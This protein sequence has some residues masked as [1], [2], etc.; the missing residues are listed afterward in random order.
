VLALIALSCTAFDAAA[1]V[2]VDMNVSG[3]GSAG[4][5]PFSAGGG[6]YP[7]SNFG[8]SANGSLGGANID[9][10]VASSTRFAFPS[11]NNGDVLQPGTSS[12]AVALSPQWSGS[13]SATS[14]LTANVAFQYNLGP[15]SG[16]DS[17]FSQNLGTSASGSI[18]NAGGALSSNS[19]SNSASGTVWNYHLGLD[20]GV[21]SAS[22]GITVG[23]T[24][25]SGANYSPSAQYGVT[26]WVSTD[27]GGAP[28]GA[29]A[30]T[31]SGGGSVD[32]TVLAP[33]G[34]GSGTQ[35]YLHYE[36]S[37]AF[38]M[39]VTPTSDVSLPITGNL[40]GEA[41]GET[42]FD[43]NFPLGNLFDLALSYD[44]WDVAIDWFSGWNY[45]VPAMWESHLV[46]GVCLDPELNCNMLVVDGLPFLAQSS[47]FSDSGPFD[48]TG[49]LA[50]GG[51]NPTV[52]DSRPV[53]PIC[54]PASGV[55]YASNDPDMPLGGPVTIGHSIQQ[56]GGGSV[57]APA[58]LA[59]LLA[60]WVAM[61]AVPRRFRRAPGTAMPAP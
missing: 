50:R 23:D 49:L 24:Y 7:F 29:T 8:V 42:V 22:A 16:S 13:V 51:W 12:L 30:S 21:G 27:R 39:P 20:A 55:C 43:Y 31:Q 5:A 28:V 34:I 52:N 35:V 9:V 60:G 10:S 6:P 58:P 47:G 17:I 38:D 54:D 53:P 25:R 61:V 56:V 19:V 41:F 32:S 2:D 15:W 18:A 45:V 36:P 44:P 37:I 46:N 33:T 40:H 59:L 4:Y 11:F 57:P 48:P 1:Q 3:I 14:S 26:T